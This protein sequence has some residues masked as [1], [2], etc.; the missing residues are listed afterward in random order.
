M[1]LILLVDD[2]IVFYCFVVI[3][4]YFYHE[5]KNYEGYEKISINVI[6]N[7]SGRYVSGR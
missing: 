1:C 6:F 7:S 2:F 4:A 5:I 3:V